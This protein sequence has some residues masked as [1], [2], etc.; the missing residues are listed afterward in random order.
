M[1]N[2]RDGTVNVDTRKHLK[3]GPAGDGDGVGAALREAV[4]D[5]FDRVPEELGLL[6]RKLERPRRAA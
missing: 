6:L 5:R 3:P 4:A 2:Q 1:P